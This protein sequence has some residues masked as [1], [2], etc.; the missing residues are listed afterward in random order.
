ME[1]QRA[2]GLSRR[3][4]L[5]RGLFGGAL[6]A[7]GGSTALALRGGLELPLPPE[8]L[9]VLGAREYA[10][11]QA[12]ARRA[13]PDRKGWP[14]ADEARVAFLADGVLAA[15]DP[16]IAKEVRQLLGL[17]DNALVGFLFGGHVRPFSRLSPEEQDEVLGE[18]QRSKL[19]LRRTGFWALRTL[20]HASYYG[21]TAAQ[22]AVGYAPI[23][24]VH[25]ANAPAWRGVGPRP[26]PRQ[27]TP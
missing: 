9:K 16:A 23:S 6:L 4:L 11:L 12:I 2:T 21:T 5:K 13:L 17:F 18:W 1:A 7:V 14:T 3:S 20:V 8:G 15:S 22:T 10:T 24:G 25:D 19:I 26:P 27:E